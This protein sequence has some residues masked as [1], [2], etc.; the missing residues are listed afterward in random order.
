MI[1]VLGA[2][3]YI[4]QAFAKELTRRK[5]GWEGCSRRTFDYSDFRTLLNRLNRDRP[6]LVIHAAGFTGRPNVDACET[7]RAETLAGNLTLTV[8]V[9]QACAAAGVRL[10]YVSSG[11]IFN[12]AKFR[13]ASGAWEIRE[14]LNQ[15]DLAPILRQ[16]SDQLAGFHEGDDPNFTFR[17]GRCS[18]YSG[19]KALSEEAL[20]PFPEAYIWR[21]RI[22]FDEEDG[23]RNYLSK[24]QTYAKIYDNWN[25]LSH[26][27]DFVAACL[28]LWEKRAAGG[29]YNLTNPGYVCTGEVVAAIQQKL[30]PNWR[31]VFWADDAEFYRLGAKAPRSN[32]IL[33]GP[34]VREA[35]VHLRPIGE[36]LE[37]AVARWDR[38]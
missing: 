13:G 10:G 28:D 35:G 37:D 11:C 36:A 21:L 20:R 4:G 30:R 26:R 5:L 12:G 3:G 25:S 31:P 22:P 19:S 33:A 29:A 18:F 23:P 15:P 38:P 24:I 1:W 7:L 14:Q 6:D 32:C 8:T 9:A 27:G 17:Q 2:S 34:R 16:R